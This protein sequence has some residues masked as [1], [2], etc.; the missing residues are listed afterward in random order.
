MRTNTKVIDFLSLTESFGQFVKLKFWAFCWH[1]T[2]WRG[3]H[4]NWKFIIFRLIGLAKQPQLWVNII[5]NKLKTVCSQWVDRLKWNIETHQSKISLLDSRID[6]FVIY[7][8]IPLLASLQ[9]SFFILDSFLIRTIHP[10]RLTP[11]KISFPL[12]ELIDFPVG[13]FSSV[14][15][16]PSHEPSGEERVYMKRWTWNMSTSDS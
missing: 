11:T 7:E 2:N 14:I 15:C 13:V 16:V 5:F 4:L 10:A 3:G 9:N 1:C 6:K 12:R 8:E